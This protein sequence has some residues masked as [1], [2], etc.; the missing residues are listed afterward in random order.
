[1]LVRA[2]RALPAM[3]PMPIF[4]S[5][6]A[7]LR[8][9]LLVGACI[10]LMPRIGLAASATLGRVEGLPREFEGHFFDVPLAVRVDLDG[11]YLGDAMVV[12][13]RDEQVQLLEFTETDESREPESLRQRWQERLARPR[14]LGDCLQDCPDGL[15][16]VHYSLVN[17]QLSLLTLQAES[18]GQVPRFHQPPEQGSTGLLLRNQLNL[19]G[20]GRGGTGR[21]AL[22]GQGSIGHWTALADGQLDRGS[23]ADASTRYHV[24]Q[25]Y[26]E[27]LVED[28]FYRLGYFTPSAQGLTR[29]PRLNGAS[30]DT[31]LG[32]MFGSSDGLA[33]D[34]GMPS[35][36]PIYV[37]PD[38]P[39][40]VE[41]YRNGVLINSQP[42]QPGLQTLDTRVLPGGIYEVEVRLV[43]DGQVTSRDQAFI[44]KPS[45]WSSR[46]GRWRYNVYLGRQSSVLSNWSREHDDSLSGG[47]LANYLLHPRA[48]VGVSVQQIDEQQQ[49]GT[50]LDWDVHERFKLYGNLYQAR[51]YGNGYDLQAVGNFET[52]SL[53]ASHSRSWLTPQTTT[54]RPHAALATRQTS[55]SLSQRLDPRHTAN[56]RVS[57]SSGASEGVGLDLGWSYYGRLFGSDANWR[58]SV[59][60]RPGT[61]AT[62]ES[63]SRG[64]N[65]ALSMSLGGGK[66]RRV[67]AT[68]GTRTSRDGGRDINTSLTYQQDLELGP[69]RS[70]GAT[71]SADRYGVGLG[72][73]TQFENEVMHGDAY[74][75]QSSYNG[76][77]SGGVNLESLLALGGGK[78]ALSGQYLPHQAGLIVDVDS[79]LPDLKLHAEDPNGSTAVLRPGRNVIPV[80]AYKPGSVQ[81]DFEGIDPTAALI[82]PASLDYHLNRG[83]IAYRQLRV[84]RTVTVLGRLFDDKGQPL[85]GAQVINHASRSVTE[86]DG[87]F[88][89][90]MSEATPTLEVRLKGAAVCLLALDPS[91]LVREGDVLLAGDQ[92]CRPGELAGE[93]GPATDARSG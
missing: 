31:T 70:V 63:R 81:F 50:S 53:V 86:V 77:F 72:G 14:P 35:T 93:G 71:V 10:A 8:H 26:A 32:L 25:L 3:M 62:G 21:F 91:R 68:V 82:Q 79:D 6:P 19:V 18:A 55:L 58:L 43:E 60:D 89:V 22:Q 66:G 39:A 17:S 76:E 7:A 56:L 92:Q 48:V 33:L 51:G 67:S 1:M 27:R 64:V 9:C 45:N 78:V 12:L 47:I 75:Q 2:G 80:A 90:E 24:E 42:V 61:L 88:A 49:F 30:P 4:Q 54:Q 85:R 11:R 40:I 20:D 36:T 5:I 29:Q 44:Y 65:L 15:Q 28:H 37:T 84:M 38:R 23:E 41:I 16:A 46:G 74:V 52:T 69:L 73:D 83:G 34:T 57:H 87:F 59:F 13:G